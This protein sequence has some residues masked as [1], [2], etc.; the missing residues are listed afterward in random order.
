MG[1]FTDHRVKR[2]INKRTGQDLSCRAVRLYG[3]MVVFNSSRC[4]FSVFRER[5]NLRCVLF[6]SSN[7]SHILTLVVKPSPE[8]Q[9]SDSSSAF[10]T[11]VQKTKQ[12]QK[13]RCPKKINLFP[14][15]I[16]SSILESADCFF[17]WFTRDKG[18]R[19]N[20]TTK[21]NFSRSTRARAGQQY[22]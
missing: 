7:A 16:L 9:C 19:H 18:K 12:K 11:R 5:Y 1:V 2:P 13:Q 17:A 15:R 14:C 21:K 8:M 20:T 6:V 3:C 4:I 10:L 22:V